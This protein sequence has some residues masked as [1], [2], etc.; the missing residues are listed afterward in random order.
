MRIVTAVIVAAGL[1]LTG[2]YA[3]AQPPGGKDGGKKG[4]PKISNG[5]LVTYL[6]SFNKKKDGKLTKEELTDTRLH[7]LFD[8]ADADKDGFVTE[9]ELTTLVE[10]LAAQG[11]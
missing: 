10:K 1:L 9:K 4:S 2:A 7:R 6:M 3:A 11:K 5:D 8:E